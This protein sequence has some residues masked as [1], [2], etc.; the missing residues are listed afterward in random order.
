VLR[1]WCALFASY[2]SARKAKVEAAEEIA[3]RPRAA[4]IF[5][6]HIPFRNGRAAGALSI[7]DPLI[8]ALIGQNS[9]DDWETKT[10]ARGPRKRK[11]GPRRLVFLARNRSP[12][13]LVLELVL[14]LDFS[15]LPVEA[16]ICANVNEIS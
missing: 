1:H 4:E 16:R 13:V 9:E 3:D 12:I 8:A 6:D 11:P 5:S 14:V 7:F 2:P 15:H 10:I